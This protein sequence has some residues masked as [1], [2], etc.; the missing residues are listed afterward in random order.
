MGCQSSKDAGAEDNKIDYTFEHTRL[1]NFDSFFNKASAILETCEK[2]R[3]GLEDS[4]ADGMELAGT[5]QLEAPKYIETLRVLLWAISAT[6]KGKNI[7]IE[8]EVTQEKPYLDVNVSVLNEETKKLYETFK[9]YVN[10]VTDGPEDIKTAIENLQAIVD[11][12]PDVVKNAKSEIESSS[13]G[14]KEKAQAVMKVNKNSAKLP[15]QL[16]KVKHLAEVL[17]EAGTDLKQTVP[18][19]K[20]LVKG[21]GDT[22]KKAADA[23]LYKP[24]EIFDKFHTGERNAEAKKEQAKNQP[25]QE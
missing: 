7:E 12:T 8:P 13:L 3:G 21:A 16:K 18:E 2:I 6:A 10:T 5:D 11:E 1:P 4:K 24:K 19:L 23:K 15:K 14:F 9:E 22:G 20:T 25:K 17:K